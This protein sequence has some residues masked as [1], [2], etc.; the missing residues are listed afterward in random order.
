[1][2]R[3]SQGDRD[4]GAR[5]PQRAGEFRSRIRAVGPERPTSQKSPRHDPVESVHL[6]G[7]STLGGILIPKLP[8]VLGVLQSLGKK[9]GCVGL[10]LQAKQRDS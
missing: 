7:V 9:A 6:R 8:G 2:G 5:S 4:F 10:E 3:W 1:M